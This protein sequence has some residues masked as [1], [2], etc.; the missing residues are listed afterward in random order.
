MFS[1]WDWL[2]VGA[3]I[4]GTTLVGHRLKGRQHSTRDFFLG[5][6]QLPWYAVTAS[7][8]ATTISAITF[9]GVPALVFAAD[10]NY[11][12]LQLAIGEITDGVGKR[13]PDQSANAVED[14]INAAKRKAPAGCDHSDGHDYGAQRGRGQRDP[15]RVVPGGDDDLRHQLG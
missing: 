3:Y 5:G 2:I 4:A 7:T 15:Q 1:A 13:R 8:I 9:I 11:V 6:R 12:Y 14:Q 10:G